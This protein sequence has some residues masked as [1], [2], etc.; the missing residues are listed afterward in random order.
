MSSSGV[1]IS[2]KNRRILDRI[3]EWL[4]VE[5]DE[6]LDILDNVMNLYE[7]RGEKS[8]SKVQSKSKKDHKYEN[9]YENNNTNNDHNYKT[10]KYD[11]KPSKKK[12]K[13]EN[14]NAVKKD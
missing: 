1:K 13:Y 9:K 3:N 5:T 11:G 6:K 4:K 8:Q 14:L 7:K 10:I 12:S 2:E